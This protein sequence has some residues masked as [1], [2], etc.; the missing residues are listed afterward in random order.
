MQIFFDA[1]CAAQAHAVTQRAWAAACAN[2]NPD[3]NPN[4]NPNPN[5]V[6]PNPTYCEQYACAASLGRTRSVK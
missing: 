4:P 3:P 6:N 1:A 2:P 5:L